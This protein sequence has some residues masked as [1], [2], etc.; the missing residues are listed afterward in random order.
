MLD[1]EKFKK[2]T[3]LASVTRIFTSFIL[4]FS[5]LLLVGLVVAQISAPDIL[6]NLPSQIGKVMG[7]LVVLLILKSVFDV[8][9]D[10]YG[11]RIS[12]LWTADLVGGILI[13]VLFQALSTVALLQLGD[14][15]IA[16]TWSMGVFDSYTTIAVAI[17]S[18][19][20]SFFIIGLSEDL[21]FRGI[22]IRE[23]VI[24]FKSNGLSSRMAAL[25]SVVLSSILFG[26]IHF[27]AG[28][29][30][31]STSVVIL[32][33][34]IAGLYFGIAYVLT[35]SLAIPVGIH[36]STNLWTTVVFGEPDSG[37]PMFAGFNRSVELEL[38]LLLSL[39][40]PSILLLLAVVVWVKVTRKEALT[41][42]LDALTNSD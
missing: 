21:L 16:Y 29:S 30:G 36:F 33:A 17:T 37:Y 27:A 18:T 15:E 11:L 24:G 19:C 10:K 6:T 32:Q 41:F 25:A 2:D 35:D 13:G 12:K 40:L 9:P 34:I 42:D 14:A 20:I 39:I 8:N 3:T 22:M 28:A 4:Y 23:F 31:L 38:D 26:S 5:V 1:T 7:V